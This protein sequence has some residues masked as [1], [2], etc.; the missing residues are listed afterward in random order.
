MAKWYKGDAH[1]HTLNSD[2]VL[3]PQELLARCRALGLDWAIV[4]DHNFD[5]IQNGSYTDAG[6]TVIR[7]QEVTCRAGHVNVWGEKVPFDP[8]YQIETTE[9]YAALI[10]ACK[11]A[12]A[13]TSVNHPFCSQCGVRVNVNEL[14]VDCVEV[15]NT[16]QHTDNLSNMRWWVGQL[17]AG[18][19]L[20]AVG[21]S[22]FQR[23]Y[24]PLEMLAMPTTVVYAESPEPDDILKA[25]KEGRSVV[26]NR[27]D[28]SML[29]L[30][31]GDAGVG[32]TA[33]FAK[34]LAG[35]CR[36]TG[37][38]RG[39]IL[40]VFNNETVVYEYRAARAQKEYAAR[41]AI[42]EPGFIRAQIDRPLSAPM[43]AVLKKGEGAFI[44][45]QVHPVPPPPKETFW[46][47][48]N[49]IWIK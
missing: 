20:A 18:R 14:P 41:F 45:P 46:A 12:G 11:A 4:T 5:T 2:G 44:K 10:R 43:R 3:Q 15:W 9:D 13:V 6:L 8:P 25:L 29:Y 42:R 49:P 33:P 39:H 30:N 23:D 19:R 21:G 38:R 22:D 7:G 47:F 1:M 31:V 24:G 32:D 27:P 36:V 40:R 35:S 17:L 37:L 34:G 26:T 28:S 48:T 16:I